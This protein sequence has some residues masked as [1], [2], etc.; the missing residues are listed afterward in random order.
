MDDTAKI[1]VF[2][3]KNKILKLEINILFHPVAYSSKLDISADRTP[4]KI[5]NWLGYPKPKFP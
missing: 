2:K 5:F 1:L 3:N 4:E